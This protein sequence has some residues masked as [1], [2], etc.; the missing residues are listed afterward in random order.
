[1][2]T[3]FDIYKLQVGKFVFE[4]ENDIGPS[5]S[6]IK[7]IRAA[8]IHNH[9]TRFAQQGNFHVLS[10]RTTKYGLKTLKIQGGKVWKTIPT[11]IQDSLSRNAFISKYK[12][13]LYNAYINP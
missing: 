4:S 8:E 5:R 1:M 13:N 11:G 12:R 10:V 2:L 7:Y 9:N 3:I 6:I